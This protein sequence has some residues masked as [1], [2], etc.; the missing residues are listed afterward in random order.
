MQQLNNNA[1]KQINLLHGIP[2]IMGLK[3][4]DGFHHS[5]WQLMNERS[6]GSQISQIQSSMRQTIS[7]TWVLPRTRGEIPIL[8]DYSDDDLNTLLQCQL[9]RST[10]V[11]TPRRCHPR[12]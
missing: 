9:F 11:A 3:Q 6:L 12:I 10:W 7:S 2:T 1:N 4:L 5:L 8:I